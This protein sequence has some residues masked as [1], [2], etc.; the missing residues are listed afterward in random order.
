MGLRLSD[1]SNNATNF[2]FES[3]KNNLPTRWYLVLRDCLLTG[4]VKT[5]VGHYEFSFSFYENNDTTYRSE[6]SVLDKESLVEESWAEYPWS[7]LPDIEE[8]F[9]CY[10]TKIFQFLKKRNKRYYDF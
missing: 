1:V 5:N 10:E 6:L 2:V 9:S 7:Y 4:F 3:L 8:V